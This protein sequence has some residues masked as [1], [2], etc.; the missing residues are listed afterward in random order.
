[1]S[2]NTT[3]GTGLSVFICTRSDHQRLGKISSWGQ[4]LLRI[5]SISGTQLRPD[6]DVGTGGVLFGDSQGQ[7]TTSTTRPVGKSKNSKDRLRTTREL[8][9]AQSL[10]PLTFSF[11]SH[12]SF[13]HFSVSLTCTP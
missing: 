2:G 11:P 6:P 7:S 13:R 12:L 4:R 5:N 9:L 10:F 8:L 3:R 1:M